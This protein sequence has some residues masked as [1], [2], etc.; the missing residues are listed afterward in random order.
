[1]TPRKRQYLAMESHS[2][3][4][5]ILFA[6]CTSAAVAAAPDETIVHEMAKQ[7]HMPA[8]DIR[9]DYDACDSGVTL[10]MKI[11]GSYRWMVE[12]A[13]LNKAYKQA[14]TKAREMGYES[15]LVRAQ[16]AWLA[17]RDAACTYEGEMG[18]GGGTAE[19]LYVLGCKLDLTKQQA[20]R[21]ENSLR[22]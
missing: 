6:L 17:Y 22:E 21:L 20:D 19:G 18:A 11:C 15:S 8:D 14:L 1:M 10:S 3:A 16:R 12:D 4:W 9:R 2:K 5:V 13:R 7:T